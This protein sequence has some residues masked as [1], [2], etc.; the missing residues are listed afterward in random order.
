MPVPFEFMNAEKPLTI[1][2][3]KFEAMLA[4]KQKDE[5]KEL[6][7]RVKARDVPASVKKNKF[8]RMQ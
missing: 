5:A 7:T 1:R 2:Q 4:E 8:E 3:Q 6:A